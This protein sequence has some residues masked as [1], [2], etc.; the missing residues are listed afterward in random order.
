MYFCSLLFIYFKISVLKF[1]QKYVGCSTKPHV[2]VWR[3]FGTR[4][5]LHCTRIHIILHG[6]VQRLEAS[7]WWQKKLP[8]YGTTLN[9]KN[10][11]NSVKETFIQEFSCNCNI[12][13]SGE[14][15]YDVIPCCI[16]IPNYETWNIFLVKNSYSA[17][18]ARCDSHI[19]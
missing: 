13:A 4:T 1:T 3:D 11:Q 8:W 7:P 14:V 6:F 18:R 10:L 17:E 12:V 16:H 9:N 19:T 5:L 15:K 2:A